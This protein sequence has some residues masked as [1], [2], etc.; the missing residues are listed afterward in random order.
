MAISIIGNLAIEY[1]R[2]MSLRGRTSSGS[3]ADSG[4]LFNAAT[5]DNAATAM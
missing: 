1:G 2:A 4:E 3:D 5:A